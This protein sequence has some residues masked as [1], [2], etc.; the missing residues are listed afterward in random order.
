MAFTTLAALITVLDGLSLANEKTHLPSRPTAINAADM[1]LR[2]CRL[3]DLSS[4]SD[5]LAYGQG[6]KRSKIEVVILVKFV[7]LDLQDANDALT[8]TLMDELSMAL[9]DAAATLGMDNYHIA[10]TFEV[11]NNGTQGIQAITATIEV[12]G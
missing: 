4:E 1:P 3:P 11:T 9:V 12:S 2:Y 6:L 10:P 7:A 5:T 8:V